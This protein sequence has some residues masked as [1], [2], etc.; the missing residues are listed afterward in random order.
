[1][2]YFLS[3]LIAMF[4]SMLCIPFLL[5]IAYQFNLLDQP[6]K[7]R[8]HSTPIPR[9]GGVALVI[10]GLLPIILLLP[11]SSQ[12]VYLIIGAIIIFLIGL[13]DDL[14]DLN[15]KIKLVAQIL[16]AVT[17]VY[18]ADIRFGEFNFSFGS[19]LDGL[20]IQAVS[21]VFIVA[22]TN[23]LNLSDGM[24]GLAAGVALLSLSVISLL[25]IES[26]SPVILFFS[27]A[28]IGGIFGFLRFNT[29]PAK[30]F[31]GDTGS[32]FLGYMLAVMLLYMVSNSEIAYSSVLPILIIG[33]PLLDMGV[34]V[35]IRLMNGKSPFHAD[36]NHFH[37]KLLA[38]GYPQ[39]VSVVILYLLQLITVLA[40]YIIREQKDFT[41]ILVSIFVSLLL[42][43]VFNF[44]R[45]K[46][47]FFQFVKSLL[48][49]TYCLTKLDK[50][51]QT[52]IFNIVI[53]LLTLWLIFNSIF[54][55]QSIPKDVTYF[56]IMLSVILIWRILT[57]YSHSLGWLERGIG[58]LIAVLAVYFQ[59]ENQNMSAQTYMLELVIL[60]PLSI[61]LVIK[62]IRHE[63]SGFKGNPL[64]FLI[65]L[66]AIIGPVFIF[67]EIQ[68]QSVS[69]LIL[70]S[71]LLFYCVEIIFIAIKNKF[72]L[73]RVI[74]LS[75]LVI[76][77]INGLLLH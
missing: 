46:K 16:A 30:I 32:Q 77:G 17:V 66:L 27:L 59:F 44:L 29:Y 7:R 15:Y 37:H 55:I 61:C 21:I 67:K 28:L 57:Q 38:S 64:D 42:I 70:K 6:D 14:Y 5:K 13:L 45:S 47:E 69:I 19:Q 71:I 73:V 31:M 63:S 4:T 68:Y 56:S 2:V 41:V 48:T 26:N 72:N 53:V 50:I 34:V 22:T 33:L 20:F 24:D 3:F 25:S 65:L 40:A 1:M 39:Y 58:Y 76:V 75:F 54:F 62:M 60:L 23:A 8:I 12:I 35:A 49:K 11:M 10:A 43:L 52:G 18:A 9:L 36:Q 74:M 51:E